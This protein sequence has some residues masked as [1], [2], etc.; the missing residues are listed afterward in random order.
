MTNFE[1]LISKT[2]EIGFVTQIVGGIVYAEGLPGAK[3]NEIIVFENGEMGQ[4]LALN[5]DLI[6]ILTFSEK[7]IKVG[8]KITRNNSIFML[9]IG[10]D[11]LG[12]VIDPLGN[13]LSG[14]KSVTK[15]TDVAPID[16]E[17]GGIMARKGIKK[18]FETGTS[19]VDLMIPL[20]KGQRELVIGD[21]KTGKTNFLL[22][23]ILTQARLGNICILAMVGK[24]KIDIKKAE[25]FFTANKIINQVIIIAS[26]ST[27][28][29][30]LIFVTPYSAMA[31][32]EY[33]RNKGKDV[34]LVLDDMSTHA[35]FYREISLLGKRFPGRNSY[36]GDIF[37]VHAKLM[38]RAGNFKLKDDEAA[39][40][41]LPVVETTQGDLSGYIQTNLMSMTDGHLFFDS[42]L[43]S[44]GRRPAL[45]PFLSVTRVGRQTQS[46]IKRSINRELTSFLTLYEKIQGFI[47]FG[48][49]LNDTAKT[50]LGIGSKITKLFDQQLNEFI[51]INVQ[52][53][54]FTLL[55][56]SLLNDLAIE[57]IVEKREKLISLYTKDAKFAKELN[58]FIESALSLNELLTKVEKKNQLIEK[59]LK[60]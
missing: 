50:T 39:I 48:S 10:E 41:C 14:Q 28:P 33:F 36:P 45:N 20:G 11:L 35:K 2:G 46:E 32:A 17:P 53:T 43:F 9:P 30:G 54:I 42:N 26:N 16:I 57:Q 58:E 15:E 3:P 1:K 34:L 12:K 29:A 51:P 18:Y 27:D 7:S 22:N 4:V 40:T 47:H 55:W 21:R 56:G 60:L 24:R 19:I 6:E 31:A 59:I 5:Q 49:E 38:E 25:E 13:P 8:T 37:Y 52:V 23:T 44:Q